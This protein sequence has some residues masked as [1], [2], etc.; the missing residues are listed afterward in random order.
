LKIGSSQDFILPLSTSKAK[1][2]PGASSPASSHKGETAIEGDV[3][4]N[5]LLAA[6][7]HAQFMN[8]LP[9]LEPWDMPL[10]QVLYE[11]GKAEHFVYFPTSAIVSLLYVMKNGDSAEIAVVGNEGLVGISLFMGGNSTP[12]RAVVQSGG[13]GYRLKAQFMRC[14]F[15]KAGPVTSLLL[16]YTQ[17][18][19]TQ[20]SQTAVCNRHHSLD[21]QLCRWL[22]LSLDRLVGHELVMTQ[23]LIANMLGVRRGGVTEA[24]LKLQAVG[25]I[26]YARGRINVLDRKG[27]EERACECYQVVKDEYDRLLPMEMAA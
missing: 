21:E 14:E 20:M 16:R 27:L 24:A 6:L 18:L 3:K 17:A 22:L 19:I 5:R 4:L 9:N 15:D 10:G 23:E 2:P 1:P 8:W 11:S 13:K 26:N 25:L 7:P 12:S